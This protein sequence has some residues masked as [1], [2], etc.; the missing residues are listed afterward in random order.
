MRSEITPKHDFQNNNQP[1]K[2]N[3]SYQ[4]S[5][6]QFI[7]KVSAI[8]L[9]LLVHIKLEVFGNHFL[10]LSPRKVFIAKKLHVMFLMHATMA[11]I[12][13]KAAFHCLQ[14]M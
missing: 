6:I 10:V 9:M 13:M 3:P 5:T 12:M 14:L 7:L 8:I 1:I 4:L 11:I 2:S